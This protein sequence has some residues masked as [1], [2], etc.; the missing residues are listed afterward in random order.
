[1]KKFIII[2]LCFFLVF[3][4]PA[5]AN[6]KSLKEGFYKVTDLNVSE[7][8]NYTIQNISFSERIYMIIFDS[9]AQ[10]LQ[11]LRLK[12]QSKK[13]NLVSLKPGYKIVLIGDGEIVISPDIM[14]K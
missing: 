1:M 14:L 2:F 5:T 13:Y 7:D 9:Y 11:G 12:P 6:P 10:P 4:E 3:I 8:T